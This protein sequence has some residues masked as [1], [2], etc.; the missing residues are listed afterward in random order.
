MHPDEIADIESALRLQVGN[1]ARLRIH[2]RDLKSPMNFTLNIAEQHLESSFSVFWVENAVPEMFSLR[3]FSDPVI[4]FNTRLVELW[5]DTRSLFINTVFDAPLKIEL[6][7]R[8]CLKLMAERL[9]WKHSYPEFAAS[10]ILRAS[11]I[12]PHLILLPNTLQSIEYEP[13]S[14]V[15]MACWFYGLAHE[16]GHFAARITLP[17]SDEDIVKAIKQTLNDF[18]ILPEQFKSDAIARATANESG[19]IL[20]VSSVREEGLADIFATS[21]ILESTIKILREIGKEFNSSDLFSF[22][23][24]M[25]I[26]LNIITIIKRCE[27][28]CVV[29]SSSNFRHQN[30]VEIV[31]NT[32]LHP[33]LVSVRWLMVRHYLLFAILRYLYGDKWTNED[34]DFINSVIDSAV[35]NIKPDIDAMEKGMTAAIE[36]AHNRVRKPS[37]FQQLEDWSSNEMDSAVVA[38]FLDRARMQQRWAPIFDAVMAKLNNPSAALEI[39]VDGDMYW[40]PFVFGLDEFN[41]PFSLSTRHGEIIFVFLENNLLCEL[42]CEISSENL[43]PGFQITPALIVA[44]SVNQLEQAIGRNLNFG[45]AFTLVVEG[46]E[47]FDQLIKELVGGTIW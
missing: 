26:S 5:G 27:R 8:L 19:F 22:I 46:T 43:S 21:V 4:V 45:T 1:F 42:F 6:L 17:Y 12:Q 34:R 10:V 20:A 29:A 2:E 11:A 44:Y 36:F 35:N 23:S 7:E 3:G 15:Y 31:Q 30:A 28:I 41:C 18:T 16:L 39:D 33:V 40:C 24:E 38:E 9:L 13:I 37:F 32:L 25:L 47:I 14:P